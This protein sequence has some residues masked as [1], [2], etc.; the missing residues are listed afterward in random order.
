MGKG[1][2]QRQSWDFDFRCVRMRGG[3]DGV[4][5]KNQSE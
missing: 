3:G 5:A 1:E 2:V 4:L